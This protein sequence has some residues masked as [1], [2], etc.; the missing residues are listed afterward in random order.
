MGCV[1][2]DEGSRPET[3]V[4]YITLFYGVSNFNSFPLHNIAII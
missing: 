2:V 3:S 4:K 1:G